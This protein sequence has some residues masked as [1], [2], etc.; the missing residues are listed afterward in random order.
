VS[1]AGYE[2]ALGRL[3]ESHAL[4]LRLTDAGASAARICAELGIEREGLGP[5]LDIARRKLH[6]ELTR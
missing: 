2:D 6:R 5:L 3:P 1:D 4:A